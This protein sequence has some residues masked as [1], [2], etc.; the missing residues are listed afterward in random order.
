[1]LINFADKVVVGLAGPAIRKDLALS[2]EQFGLVGSSF[3]FLFAVSAIVVGFMSNRVETRRTLLIMAVVWS[4]VQFP[5]LGTVSLE[6]LIASR[7]V[8]GPAKAPPHRWPRMRSTNGSRIRCA[9]CRPPSSPGLRARRHRRRAGAHLDHRELFLALGVRRARHRRLGLGRA[10]ADLRPRRHAG[11][12]PGRPG[13]RQRGARAL[14]L[15]ADLPQHRGGVRRG[16]ASYWGL[17]LGLTWFTSYL[18][19]GLGYSQKVA[20]NLTVLPWVFGLVVV[21]SGGAISQ[22][23]KTAGVSSRLCRGA[24][25]ASTVVLGAASCLSSAACRQP[26]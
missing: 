2:P 8:L 4:L 22:R 13:R 11:R 26:G 6:V 18:T 1:M 10:V 23:L 19:D 12:S 14:P 7:I 20:G 15:P 3:F 16:L 24:F 17:A 21:L 9:A 25:A 5:M